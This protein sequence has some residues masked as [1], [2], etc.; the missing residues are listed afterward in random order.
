MDKDIFA[1]LPRDEAK[2]LGSI[3]PF[4]GS[5]Y[6]VCHFSTFLAFPALLVRKKL[7]R[8]LYKKAPRLV[9]LGAH[10]SVIEPDSYFILRRLYYHIP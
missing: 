9:S 6:S 4:D 8:L 10:L 3:E 7:D 1:P 2:A 5:C